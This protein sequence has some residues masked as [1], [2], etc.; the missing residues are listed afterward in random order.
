M[1]DTPATFANAIEEAE[2][3]AFAVLCSATGMQSGRNA[4]IGDAGDRMGVMIFGFTDSYQADAAF[5][6]RHDFTELPFNA[7]ALG[8]FRTRREVWAW[9]LRVVQGLPITQAEGTLRLFRV[10][11]LNSMEPVTVNMG[12]EIKLIGWQMS[13]TFNTASL[14]SGTGN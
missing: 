11:R 6:A 13:I 1:S 5:W 12:G 3:N 8:R 10:E 14:T 2:L 4:F 9:A 7:E